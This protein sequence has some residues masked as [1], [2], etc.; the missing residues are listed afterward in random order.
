MEFAPDQHPHRRYNPL[1]DEWVLV[2]PH[3][4]QRPWQG[5]VEK[6]GDEVRPSHDPTCY[7]CPG[8]QRAGG[9]QNPNFTSTFVFQNDFSALL[10]DTPGLESHSASEAIYR[11]QPVKGECRVICFSPRHDLTLAQMSPAEI[12]PV[13][14]VWK[15]QVAELKQWYRWVQVFENKGAAMGCSNPHPHG[16]IWA[17]ETVP[18][19][20]AREDAQQLAYFDKHGR[21][22]LQ[23]VAKAEI[24]NGER[25][26]DAN[27]RWLSIVPFWAVWPFELLIL[28]RYEVNCFTKLTGA[29]AASL[30]DLLSRSLVRYDNLFETSFPYSF[31]W[32][33]APGEA[34]RPDSWTLHAHLYP[35][36]LRSSTVRKFMVGYEMLAEAQRDLT[37]EQGAAR[38][39]ACAATRFSR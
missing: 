18:S 30:A 19:L 10:P 1:L 35:P 3:R 12:V 16:Q 14:D 39:R 7:L 8:N 21:P 25:V 24:E 29:D 38:L 20:V 22:L 26:V 17:S 23:D 13:I 32:H 2:S 15:S 34:V 11:S 37:P 33:F 27:D 28:P 4:T 31:G 9:H 6:T 36:L 5:Q